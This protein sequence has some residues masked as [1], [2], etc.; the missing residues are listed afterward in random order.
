MPDVKTISTPQGDA[1]LFSSRSRRPVATLLMSHGAGAGVD[2][3]DLEALA[4]ALPGQGVTVHLLEQPW[5]VAGRKVAGPPASLDAALRAVADQIRPRT[6]M[7]VGG[8]SAGARSACR[9]ARELGASGCLALSFPLHPPGRPEKSRADELTGARVPTLVV[10]GERDTFGRPDEFPPGTELAVVPG[11]DHSLK[12]PKRGPVT[13]EEALGI[14]VEAV[15]EWI[16]RDV[17][18]S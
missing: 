6:P 2:T 14:L 7:V 16:V 11:G 15:L 5:K 3:A 10:Q 9:M 17:A 18:G 12:V 13:Q 8:R 1:R 4:R